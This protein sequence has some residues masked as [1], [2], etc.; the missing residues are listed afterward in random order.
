VHPL[1]KPK[2]PD[3]DSQQERFIPMHP[4]ER[5]RLVAEPLPRFPW[6]ARPIAAEG[7]QRG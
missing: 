2:V 7:G 5:G 6:Q 1:P 3:Y 4:G